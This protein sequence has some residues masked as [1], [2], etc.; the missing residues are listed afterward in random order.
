M[1]QI[2]GE[3]NLP[4]LCS[5]PN[6]SKVLV[7]KSTP[8]LSLWQ[9]PLTLAEFKIFDAYL[10]RIDSHDPSRRCVRFEK[11]ELEALLGVT[12]ISLRNLEKRIQHLGIMIKV[13]DKEN[14]FTSISLFEKAE[15]ELDANGLWQIDLQCTQEAMKYIFNINNLGYLRYRLRSIVRL[16]SR[17]AY[18]LFLYL[19]QNRFRSPWEVS[20]QELQEILG[21]T[22]EFYKKSYREFNK[23]ILKKCEK[24]LHEKTSCRFTYVPVR[25]G[26]SVQRLKFFLEPF[27]ELLDTFDTVDIASDTA[28]APKMSARDFLTTALC[29][30]GCDTPEFSEA[31]LDE[32]F[33]HLFC[34]P[35]Q[36]L[37]TTGPGCVD[38]T[39]QQYHYINNK[40]AELNRRSEAGEVQNRYKYFLAMLKAD[41]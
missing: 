7:Q 15:C 10:S 31:Q 30:R 18:L 24:E 4:I 41:C 23:N 29:R 8:L 27:S 34:I 6:D 28:D 32:I 33:A 22:S 21:C 5:N 9:S 36:K 35:I 39:M 17:Y 40:F 16:R 25:M 38:I 11:G 3:E 26:R 37:P 14:G 19:E 2:Q 13:A 20:L 1:T 12:Q